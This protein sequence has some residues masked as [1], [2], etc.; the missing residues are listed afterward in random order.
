MT[1]VKGNE[2]IRFIVKTMPGKQLVG[3]RNC[4]SLEAT[5]IE[6]GARG[7]WQNF[8]AVKPI[9]IEWDNKPWRTLLKTELVRLL[10]TPAAGQGPPDRRWW[11]S[12]T[13]VAVA[14]H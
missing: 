12:K 3:M 5:I 8:V 10:K 14:V 1:P 4:Y 7:V 6:C 9:M 2:L 11:F 13:R